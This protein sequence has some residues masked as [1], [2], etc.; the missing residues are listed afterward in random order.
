[1][2]NAM[3]PEKRKREAN[4]LSDRNEK[5][6]KL[7][8]GP[9]IA[10]SKEETP[11][12]RGGG[13]VLTPLEHRQIQNQAKRD[14]LFEEGTGRKAPKHDFEDEEN[15]PAVATRNVEGIS[16]RTK[17][18][19]NKV[20]AGE[21]RRQSDARVHIDSLSYKVMSSLLPNRSRLNICSV[22]CLASL[23]LGR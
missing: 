11:F 21:P 8:S 1:M 14:V 15:E 9:Q 20:K 4:A 3:A 2:H 7:S 12:P 13:G 16:K 23:Y 5:K 10:T 17:K 19:H 6:S 18:S 22:L